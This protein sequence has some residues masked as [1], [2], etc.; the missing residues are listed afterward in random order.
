MMSHVDMHNHQIDDICILEWEP[1]HL[2]S[3]NTDEFKAQANTHIGSSTKVV[4]DLTAVTFIDSAGLGALLSLSRT[5]KERKGDFR[6]CCA[7]KAIQLLFELV[8]I[9]KILDI[10]TT[11]EEAIAASAKA[12]GN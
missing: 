12:H 9:N 1:H 3:R 2:D 5:M 8:R 6:V 4:L 7:G 11:R 10:H